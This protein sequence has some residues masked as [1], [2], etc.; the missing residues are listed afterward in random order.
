[1]ALKDLFSKKYKSNCWCNNCQTHQ[2]V[3]IPKGVTLAQYIEENTGK[4]SNCGCNTLIADYN[5]MDEYRQERKPLPQ[6]KVLHN[7][8]RRRQPPTE[9]PKRAPLP[10][11]RPSNRPPN[12]L[13][14]RRPRPSEPDFTPRGIFRNDVDFWTGKPQGRD[15]EYENY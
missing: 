7:P 5:Q 8:L 15:E 1:M 13:P 6:V 2:E 10:Q 11:Q 3:E 4:C 12:S 9:L 14:P